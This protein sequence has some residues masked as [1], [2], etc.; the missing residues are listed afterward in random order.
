MMHPKVRS[1]V[2]GYTTQ[3]AESSTR[4]YNASVLA[5][6]AIFVLSGVLH[7]VIPEKYASIVPSYLPGAVTLVY[8]SGAAE[9]VGGFGL[10]TKRFRFSAAMGLIAL[11]IA[12]FPANIEM[13]RQ[14]R[15]RDATTIV[16]GALWFRLTLQPL[17]IWWAWKTGHRRH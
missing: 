1:A 10:L 14:A 12:V 9:L 11:L 13:L 6:S 16:E 2:G 4:R 15:E 17:L 5:L 3:V 8:V 7:F